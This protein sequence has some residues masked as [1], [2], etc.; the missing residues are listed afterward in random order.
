[1][2]IHTYTCVLRVLRMLRNTLCYASLFYVAEICRYMHMALRV[3]MHAYASN[4]LMHHMSTFPIDVGALF[5]ILSS[6]SS[7]PLI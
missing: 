4:A 6:T 2:K 7:C 1:M 5:V 3:C